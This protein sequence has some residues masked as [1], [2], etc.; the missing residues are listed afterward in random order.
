MGFR[1]HGNPVTPLTGHRVSLLARVSWRVETVT[2]SL[3]PLSLSL[4]VFPFSFSLYGSPLGCSLL[5][6]LEDT[7]RGRR[8]LL[9]PLLR[10]RSLARSLAPRKERNP[11]KINNSRSCERKGDTRVPRFGTPPFAS[12]RTLRKGTFTA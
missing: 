3:H 5:R 1:C 12:I 4:S 2:P 7:F 6:I 10:A 11:I 8:L 9:P